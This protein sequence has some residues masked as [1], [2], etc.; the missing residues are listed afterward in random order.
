MHIDNIELTRCQTL[1]VA[2]LRRGIWRKPTDEMLFSD[3]DVQ[4]WTEVVE[5]ASKQGVLALAIDG[6]HG[7]PNGC[8]PPREILIKWTLGV[9]NVEDR[10]HR[11]KDALKTLAQFFA[12]R[13]VPTLGLK[14]IGL[15]LMYPTPCHR[16]GGDIDIYLWGDYEKGNQLAM[17]AGEDVD[18]SSFKHS[19]FYCKGIP[20]ENHQSFIDVKYR[21]SNAKLEEDLLRILKIEGTVDAD[22]FV[23]QFPRAMFNAVFLLKHAQAHFLESG[24]A[25]RFL[26]DW[27]LLLHHNPSLVE[28][29]TVTEVWTTNNLYP[30]ANA[31]SRLAV[32][33]FH[34]PGISLEMF[35]SNAALERLIWHDIVQ[36]EKRDHIKQDILRKKIASKFRTAVILL[37]KIWKYK[38]TGGLKIYKDELLG[39]ILLNLHLLFGRTN[40]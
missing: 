13:G 1:L 29:P 31:F 35:E 17:E 8:K 6:L 37:S 10:Y 15:S 5:L 22:D 33:I 20:V 12:K 28:E 4:T 24:I 21:K 30:F 16:E 19:S 25:L 34:P 36:Y 23:A 32:E 18:C 7:L 39:R 26:C 2:L 3:V 40:K 11:Q 14:G 38:T 9:Q 27:A